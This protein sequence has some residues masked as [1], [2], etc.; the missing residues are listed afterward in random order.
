M[1]DV[2]IKSLKS[3]DIKDKEN[4]ITPPNQALSEY[5]DRS[6]MKG[7]SG[8]EK[9]KQKEKKKADSNDMIGFKGSNVLSIKGYGKTKKHSKDANAKE[10]KISELNLSVSKPVEM[11]KVKRPAMNETNKVQE[12]KKPGSDENLG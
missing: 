1:G 10:E 8:K 3:E 11:S 12:E 6:E 9:K 4:K 5:D 2:S 7:P